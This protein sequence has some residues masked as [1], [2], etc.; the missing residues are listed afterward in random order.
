M[1]DV[2]RA[3]FRGLYAATVAIMEFVGIPVD[4]VLFAVLMSRWED[5]RERLAA[6]ARMRFPRTFEGTSFSEDGFAWYLGRRGYWWPTLPGGRL[7]LDS[8]TFDEM[9]E[10]YPEFRFLRDTRWMLRQTSRTKLADAIGKDGRNRAGLKP[11]STKTGRNAPSTSSFL[12][13]APT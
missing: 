5:L 10:W 8:D 11:F 12:L 7:A 2:N 9:I 6:R 13:A 3:L 1:I 4:M